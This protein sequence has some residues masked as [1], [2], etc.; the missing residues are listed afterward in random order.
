M[1]DQLTLKCF[2]C[3]PIIM[4]MCYPKSERNGLQHETDNKANCTIYSSNLA[5]TVDSIE[6]NKFGFL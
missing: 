5:Y 3:P 1:Y 4:L 2:W 6:K